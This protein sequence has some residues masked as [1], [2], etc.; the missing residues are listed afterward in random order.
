LVRALQDYPGRHPSLGASM[1]FPVIWH[2]YQG[3]AEIDWDN[4]A[5]RQA[6]LDGLW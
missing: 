4:A 5:A 2:K 6:F 3:R 1:I